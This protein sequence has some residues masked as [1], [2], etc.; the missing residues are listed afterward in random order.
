VAQAKEQGYQQGRIDTL[1]YLHKVLVTLAHA[2]QED[3]YFE[4][5]LHYV[6]K[7]QQAADKIRD[8]DGW[9][10]SLIPPRLRTQ[11]TRPPTL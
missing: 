10:L 4:A 9:S 6:D 8:P 1:G 11:G 5:Y 7:H 2:F 3:G